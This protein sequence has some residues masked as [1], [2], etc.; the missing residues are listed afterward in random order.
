MG[1]GRTGATGG[2]LWMN[3]VD[4]QSRRAAILLQVRPEGSRMQ[5]APVATPR[6]TTSP[7]AGSFDALALVPAA[8]LGG[9]GRLGGMACRQ[10]LCRFFLET[11]I[12]SWYHGKIS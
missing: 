1:R 3:E 10:N 12:P 5:W 8:P 4:A 11:C 6:L 2:P 7:G 9:A